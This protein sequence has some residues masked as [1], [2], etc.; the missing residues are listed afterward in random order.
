MEMMRNSRNAFDAGLRATATALTRTRIHHG[1]RWFLYCAAVGVIAG[2]GA[3]AFDVLSNTCV[4]FFLERWAGWTPVR[5]AGE[6]PFF[7][8]E[9]GHLRILVLALVPVLGGLLSGG[10]VQWLAPEAAGHGTDA[11]I[12][13]YHRKG[14]A[15]R[16]IVPLVKIIAS[17]LTLGSGGSGGREGP[18]AQVGAGFGSFLGT[19]LGLSPNDRRILVA[20]GMGA[21]VGSIFRAPLAGALFAT[22]ILYSSAEFEASV[23]IPAC[24]ASIIAYV[25]YSLVHGPGALFR[26][27]PFYFDHPFELG[28]YFILALV[29]VGVGFVYVRTFY[30]I[31]N[32][33]EHSRIPRF[34]RAAVGGFITGAIAVVLLLAT[35]KPQSLS[36]LSF[37]YGIIQ[38]ALDAP[39]TLSVGAG[40]LAL[41]AIGKILTTSFTIGS[42]GS[43]GVFGPSMVIGGCTGGATG[44]VLHRLF[45]DIVQQPGAYVLVGMAGFFAGVAKTPISTL[46]MV[47]EMTGSY[48]LLLPSLWVCVLTFALSRHWN[49]YSMQVPTRMDS[50]AHQGRFAVDVL[51]AIRVS[52][53]VEP[54]K[55]VHVLRESTP[56]SEVLTTV[57]TTDQS[58]YPVLDKGGRLLGVVS[59]EQIR[60]V[61]NERMP[62]GLV[63]ASD[64]VH[65]DTPY[66]SP[67][68]DL[69]EALRT[70]SGT[71][72]EEIPVW[73]PE[74]KTFHGLLSRRRVTQ[75]YVERMATTG[76]APR[77]GNLAKPGE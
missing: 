55:S 5:P 62:D 4:H 27:Q 46:V 72:L 19:R 29:L 35:R 42:G 56:L 50:P 32:A 38:S 8:S 54:R 3:L 61:M 26:T 70:L 20:A 12:E 36:V 10:I 6:H 68:V 53:L 67:S 31:H 75:A 37:G 49:L 22:E 51:R 65:P 43:A 25:T 48:S 76:E 63:V 41:V 57:S 30:G 74:T 45:P 58:S 2:L 24:I 39:E 1:A 28:A 59:L 17:A 40:L 71:S 44:L 33:F 60:R 77:A 34:F 21:G 66:V 13:A 14:G 47:S 23:M 64:L 18:I 69:A 16:P 7:H 15:I 73:D 11:A 52:E 9:P